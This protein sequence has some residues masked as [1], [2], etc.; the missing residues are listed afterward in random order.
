LFELHL[1]QDLLRVKKTERRFRHGYI[2]A[3]FTSR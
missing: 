3:H 1:A 2:V